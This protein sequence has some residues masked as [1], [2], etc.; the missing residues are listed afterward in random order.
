VII[1]LNGIGQSYMVRGISGV[2]YLPSLAA[3]T[4]FC[5]RTPRCDTSFIF[6]RA[7]VRIF[8]TTVYSF[9]GSV[10]F[11]MSFKDERPTY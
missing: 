2:D 7:R 10:G 11:R 3:L 8:S 4:T 1:I 9:S 5:S 6:S